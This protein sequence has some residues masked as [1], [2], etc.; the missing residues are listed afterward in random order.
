LSFSFHVVAFNVVVYCAQNF[1]KLVIGRQIGSSAL[2]IYSLSDRLMRLPLNSVTDV[3]G[4][5]IFPALSEIQTD[6]ELTRQVYL[7]AIRTIAL[8][9]FP[10]MLGLCALAEP[11]ILVIYGHQWRDAVAIVQLLCFAGL[12]QS[13][14]NT[15]GWIFLS[16]GRTDIL[17]WLG[18]LSAV[19]RVSGV[20][21]GMHWGLVGIAWAYVV[22]GYAF[23]LY[24]TCSLAGG[25]IGL[26]FGDLLKSVAPTYFC[27]LCMATI[28]WVSYHWILQEQPQWIRLLTH[29][30]MGTATYLFLI[31]SLR[32]AAWSDVRELMLEKLRLLRSGGV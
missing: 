8:F 3:F 32:L 25:L 1:D 30:V 17:F 10:M 5:V 22:G 21:I 19:V 26:R 6:L 4:A 27:A 16:Q 12:A 29:V 11:A 13:I 2:G 15:G 14:Y 7:R 31:T 20:L 18:V 24:P 28:V 23:L 9:T